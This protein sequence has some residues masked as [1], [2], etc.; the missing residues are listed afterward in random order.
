MSS[1]PVVDDV[2]LEN[3]HS[4][5]CSPRYSTS[6]T[7]T[8]NENG[9]TTTWK[10]LKSRPSKTSFLSSAYTYPTLLALTLIWIVL[11]GLKLQT[12]IT[13][14]NTNT[15][16]LQTSN[17]FINATEETPCGSTAN[18]ARSAGCLF[19]PLTFAWLP[20]ACYDFPLTS[21]FLALQEWEYYRLLPDGS[22]RQLSL[23]NLMQSSDEVVYVS[24]EF[25]RQHCAFLWL[26]MHRAMLERRPIDGVSMMDI[27]TEVCDGVFRSG[28][29]G[30]DT[31]VPGYIRFPSCK[32]Y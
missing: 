8:E 26:K 1:A 29:E 14:S 7:L 6:D 12:Q 11:A 5:S 2:I 25:H 32:V 4:A 17:F 15:N 23:I 13:T 30:N 31:S 19:D 18:A 9:E 20:P 24:W 16:S 22:Q 3:K 21:S 10:E 27:I 28:R